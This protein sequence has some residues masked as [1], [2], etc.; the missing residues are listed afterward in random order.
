ML[1]EGFS[2]ERIGKGG[3]WQHGTA[4]E[5]TYTYSVDTYGR[6]FTIDP[7]DWLNDTVKIFDEV[8]PAMG[9]AAARMESDVFYRA[10]FAATSAYFDTSLGN[11]TSGGTTNL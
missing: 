7:K 4:G 8:G 2:L 5:K 9:R 11:Y 6:I 3:E 1:S 10:L